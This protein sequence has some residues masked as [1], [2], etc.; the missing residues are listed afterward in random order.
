MRRL[1]NDLGNSDNWGYVVPD[2][3]R[4]AAWMLQ[5]GGVRLILQTVDRIRPMDQQ[6]R[7]AEV[8]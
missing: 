6:S 2:T 1:N 8:C 7:V 5:S 3:S 4:H